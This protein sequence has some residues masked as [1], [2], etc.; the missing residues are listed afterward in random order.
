MSALNRDSR[1]RLRLFGLIG[2]L[3]LGML[4]ARLFYLQIVSYDRYARH[5]QYPA[6]Y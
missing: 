1:G 2:L 4:L 5:R 6:A 3:G